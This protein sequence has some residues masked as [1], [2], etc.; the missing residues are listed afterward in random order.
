MIQIK[1]DMLFLVLHHIPLQGPKRTTSPCFVTA[2]RD[3]HLSHAHFYTKRTFGKMSKK[4]FFSYHILIHAKNILFS[5]CSYIWDF[6]CVIV[7][8]DIA[9]RMEKLFWWLLKL[10]VTHFHL[11]LSAYLY[12]GYPFKYVLTFLP[13][14]CW[15]FL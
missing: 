9:R 10:I 11:Q 8:R 13:M 3:D 14:V 4:L 6:V 1:I 15:L 2:I 12:Q 5:I 7:G